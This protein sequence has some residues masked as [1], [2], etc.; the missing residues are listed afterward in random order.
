MARLEILPIPN[1]DR[2][3][4]HE[5]VGG[6]GGFQTR[7]CEDFVRFDPSGK[8]RSNPSLCGRAYAIRPLYNHIEVSVCTLVNTKQDGTGR[9]PLGHWRP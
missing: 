5:R 4:I 7:S 6:A 8:N 3:E 1:H 9:T 2:P